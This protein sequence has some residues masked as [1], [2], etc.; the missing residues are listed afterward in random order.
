MDI[1]RIFHDNRPLNFIGKVDKYLPQLIVDLD[2]IL[3]KEI[4]SFSFET[5]K[6]SIDERQEMAA[7]IIEFAEDIHTDI[8]LWKSYEK[9]NEDLFGMPLPPLAKTRA[10][11]AE[12]EFSTVRL[13]HLLHVVYQELKPDLLISPTHRDLQQLASVISMFV[14]EGFRRRPRDSGIDR[15][16]SGSNIEAGD[17]KRKLV[18]VGTKSYLFRLSF[19]NYLKDKGQ[20]ESI[21]VIDDFVCQETTKLSGLG[22]IDILSEVLLI[23]DEQRKELRRWYERHVAY[24]RILN[25]KGDALEALN[26]ISEEEYII[27]TGNFTDQFKVDEVFL[28]SIVPWGGAWYWSG[29]QHRLGKLSAE[30]TTGIKKT[31]LTKYPR[32][33]YRYH[34]ELLEK[35]RASMA[36]Q[37]SAFVEYFGDNFVIFTDGLSMASAI[38]KKD[39][40]YY[41]SKVPEEKLAEFMAKHD[42]ENPNPNYTY[43]E[44]LLE[45]RDG[46][47]YFF[48]PLEGQEIMQGFDEIVSGFKKTG[49]DLTAEENG[50][51]HSFIESDVISPAFVN[52]MIG[53]HG[54]ESIT[55]AFLLGNNSGVECVEYFLR[56]HKGH[57]YRNRYPSIYFVE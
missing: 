55:S 29:Q 50:A 49:T 43:P 14:E 30:E 21:P 46:I 9:L 54:H 15:F 8:G 17:V 52:R 28:G 3:E 6:L 7:I 34:K 25:I 40:Q 56:K 37:H 45:S 12:S 27:N 35:A 20:K 39:R 10:K 32:L 26:I 47:G 24:Y 16:F 19:K 57:F 13:Q 44:Q 1:N 5:M 31:F 38:Q 22:V 53:D 11:K 23:T 4:N 36:E 18:W 48:N 51:I 33:Y 42:L 41:E 2:H